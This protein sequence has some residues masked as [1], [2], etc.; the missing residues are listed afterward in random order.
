M[1]DSKMA[2][3]EI[4]L[5]DQLSKFILKRES[6]LIAALEKIAKNG[7]SGIWLSIDMYQAAQSALKAF[8]REVKP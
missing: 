6:V 7:S 4:Q 2:A 8:K 3:E 1:P 5:I